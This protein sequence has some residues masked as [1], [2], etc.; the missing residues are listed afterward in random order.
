MYK[1]SR[2]DHTGSVQP[3]KKTK[4][5]NYSYTRRRKRNSGQRLIKYFQQNHGSNF[6]KSKES[7]AY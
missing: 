5:T 2:M 7:D 4:L 6:T 3:C 1:T